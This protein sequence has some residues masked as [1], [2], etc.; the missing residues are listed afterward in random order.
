MGRL[1]SE[2]D[3]LMVLGG[4]FNEILTYEEKEGGAD[5]ES[6]EM[7]G[8]KEV[9]DDC[10]LHDWRFVGQWYTWK[11]SDSLETRI[12]ETPY[13]FFVFQIWL[14]LFPE[15]YIK[16]LVRYRLDH[17]AIMLKSAVPKRPRYRDRCFKFE[18]IIL[19]VRRG[20]VLL[21]SLFKEGWRL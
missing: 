18:D 1:Y 7:R 8:F 14:Q 6:M 2:F 13:R 4:D 17:A 19:L 10:D 5:R 21:A 12:R 16:H 9:M 15:A 3:G 20:R 11:R